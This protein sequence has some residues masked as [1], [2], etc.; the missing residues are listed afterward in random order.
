M[1]ASGHPPAR[2]SNL[3][4]R[5]APGASFPVALRRPYRFLVFAAGSIFLFVLLVIG[6]PGFALHGQEIVDPEND[7]PPVPTQMDENAWNDEGHVEDGMSDDPRDF[8]GGGDERAMPRLGYRAGEDEDDGMERPYGRMR[9]RIGTTDDAPGGSYPGSF[10]GEYPPADAY[11][12]DMQAWGGQPY[13]DGPHPPPTAHPG[14]ACHGEYGCWGGMVPCVAAF[15]LGDPDLNESWQ[16]RPWNAS[17]FLGNLWGDQLI[18]GRVDQGSGLFAGY[19]FGIDFARRWGTEMRFGFSSVQLEYPNGNP[20]S[21]DTNVFIWDVNLL[22]Y[23]REEAR[24]RPFMT[25]GIGV[26]HFNFPDDMGLS[27]AESVLGMPF[28]IGVKYRWGRRLVV[29]T[30]V[31]DNLAFGRGSGLDTLHNVSFTAGFEVRFCGARKTYWPWEPGR[32]VW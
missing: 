25:T 24:L 21:L 4:R 13:P 5:C 18:D 7:Q 28:G 20:N 32:F 26:A 6:V 3:I 29:R 17:W 2:R 27:V 16:Y 12:N 10:A 14:A 19:R 8:D 23:F 22:Y 15:L 1:P 11:P 30:Q 31:I 9:T